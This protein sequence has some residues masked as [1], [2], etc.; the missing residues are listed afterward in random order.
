MDA[1]KEDAELASE[2]VVLLTRELKAARRRIVELEELL[3]EK[4]GWLGTLTI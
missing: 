1:T 2:M 4:V 3:A